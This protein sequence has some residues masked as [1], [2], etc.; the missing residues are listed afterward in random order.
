MKLLTDVSPLRQQPAFRRLWLGTMLSRTG[1]AMTTFAITLQVF[2]LTRS[3]AAVGGIGLATFIPLLVIT[4]PGGTLA[5]RVDRR[6]LVLAVTA[7]QASVS[8]ALFTL[9]ALGDASLWALY[10]LAAA[11][12]AL[13]AVGAPAGQAFIPRL[14]PKA[15]LAAA[16]ALNR[17]IF[18]VVMIAGPALAGVVAAG[19][20]LRGC[21][22]ADAASF[23]GALWGV[24]RMPAMPPEVSGPDSGASAE[25]GRPRSGLALTL[26][27]LAFIRRTPAL[28]GAF[29]ADVNATFFAL[30]V[31]LFPAINAER[32]GG[33]PRTLGL[34]MTAIGVGGL[35]SAVLGGPLRQLSRPGLVMLASVAA[36]GGAFALFAVAPSLW[37]T[38]LALALAGLAD[39][40]TV[41]V[42]GMI[43]QAAT[44]DELRGR[45][46]AADFLVGAGGGQLGSLEA[47]LVGS[48]TTPVISALSGGL[49][50]VF[51]ALAIGAALPAFRRYRAPLSPESGEDPGADAN[52]IVNDRVRA[53]EVDHVS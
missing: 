46:N 28:C 53:A 31:S 3:P 38:L 40:V 19:A 9:A 32:F 22:L 29:L 8:V 20:G 52:D 26:E 17:I 36:W 7:G 50:T 48:L 6:Q 16:M 18:Q 37:L 2:D 24:G 12:S 1:S 14:V 42:R 5:D 30:P 13:S 11:G 10:A 47:G 45:V 23:A 49:L 44:P 33:S 51:G 39:T 25:P 34:L 35:V 41:V 4:L 21:Y 43:V 15:Q 27:G